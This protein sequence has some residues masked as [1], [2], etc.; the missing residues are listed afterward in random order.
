MRIAFVSYDFGEYCVQHANG[1][2]AHGDVL[3]VL[4]VEQFGPYQDDLEVGVELCTFSKPRLRQPIRQIRTIRSIMKQIDEFRPD[5]VHFQLG[6]MWFNFVLPHLRRKYPIV[7]TVHDPR[8]HLGD[9]GA[10]KTPQ[11]L[12]D[13]GYRQADQIIVHGSQLKQI[14]ADEIGIDPK[15]IHVVPHIA[16][17]EKRAKPH[18]IQPRIR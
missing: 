14:L 4:P 11:W 16:I 5:V 7:F 1:L 3:L 17:G 15:N 12:M 8:Q 13:F 18:G 2:L 10:K 9:R 6:H